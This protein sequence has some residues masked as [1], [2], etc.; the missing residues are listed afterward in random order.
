MRLHL[1]NEV[2]K[3]L[4]PRQSFWITLYIRVHN[5][6]FIKVTRTV[7]WKT[8][9]YYCWLWEDPKIYFI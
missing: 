2:A 3:L 1:E 7:E 5:V 4:K 9:C 8:R 6:T